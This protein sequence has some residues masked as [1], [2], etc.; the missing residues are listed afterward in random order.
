M[1]NNSVTASSE[2]QVARSLNILKPLVKRELDAIKTAE[3]EAGVEHKIDCGILLIEAKEGAGA[4]EWARWIKRNFH[5]SRHTASTYMG[6][7][8]HAGKGGAFTSVRDYQRQTNPN[9]KGNSRPPN[10]Q[11]DVKETVRRMK[12]TE[13]RNFNLREHEISASKESKLE[14][15][16]ALRLIK[17]GYNVLSK[18][19]HPDRGG[20]REAMSRLNK[21]VKLLREC[22]ADTL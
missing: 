10:W 11:E 7:A 19:L 2:K 9:Y 4:G 17:I 20:S 3:L 18:E 13:M 12:Q 22:V 21:V 6:M 5:L 15:D 14:R 16:I 8:R 1:S